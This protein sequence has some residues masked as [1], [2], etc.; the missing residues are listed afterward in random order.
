MQDRQGFR[1][2]PVGYL[3]HHAGD[4]QNDGADDGESDDELES[5]LEPGRPLDLSQSE[6]AHI[7]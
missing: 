2:V 3:E 4:G 6:T 7:T 1:G 5:K